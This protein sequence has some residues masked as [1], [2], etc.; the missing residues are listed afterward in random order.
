MV[1]HRAGRHR[2]IGLLR[3]SVASPHGFPVLHVSRYVLVAEAVILTPFQSRKSLM[4]NPALDRGA[5][6]EEFQRDQR[7]RIL[8]VLRTEVA[9]RVRS[10][11]AEKVSFDYVYFLNGAVQ[12]TGEREM[13]AF[14]AKTKAQ[15]S[16]Q[17]MRNATEGIGY[18]YC[19]YVMNRSRAVADEDLGYL[20]KLFEYLNSADMLEFVE[21][22][23]GRQD[24]VRADAQYTRYSAG[25]YL[26]RHRDDVEGEVRRLAY[27]FGF[28]RRW[29]PDWGGLL[30]FYH[31]DGTP[32]DAWVPAFNCLSLF[33]IRHVHSVSYVTPFAGEARLS[34]TGWFHGDKSSSR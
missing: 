16:Q 17:L 21:Q 13:A 18:L 33:D 34:L 27:V 32:R 15:I 24:L 11:C 22:I 29:H 8:N 5:L 30:Q 6:A 1:L 31:D 2:L 25:Q 7:I 19:G 26:T 23:T 28:T 4:L 20:Y 10:I 9:E 12:V 3:T 14:D